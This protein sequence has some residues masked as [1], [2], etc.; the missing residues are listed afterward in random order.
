MQ[1][2]IIVVWSR[3]QTEDVLMHF[4]PHYLRLLGKR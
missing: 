2:R 4:N 1:V 3:L